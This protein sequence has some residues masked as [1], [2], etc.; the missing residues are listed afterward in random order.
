MTLRRRAWR[1]GAASTLKPGG[2]IRWRPDAGDRAALDEARAVVVR[3]SGGTCEGC[4]REPGTDL[5]HR[6]SRRVKRWRCDVR[7]LWW[8]CRDCHDKAGA[9][10]PGAR[11][12]GFW[13]RT[14][15][16]PTVT[17]MLLGGLR[18]SRRSKDRMR[19]RVL[20]TADGGYEE[21]ER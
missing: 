1:A 15:D 11:Y 4:L 20:L 2:R 9:G 5:C 10:Q 17:D 6:V 14:T 21:A 7:N 18:G 13:L 12:H 8:G 3:R 16:D 19:R